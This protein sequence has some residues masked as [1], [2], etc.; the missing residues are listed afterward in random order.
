[1]NANLQPSKCKGAVMEVRQLFD[2]ASSTYSYLVWDPVSREAV[3]IDPVQDQITRDLQLIR[4]IQS[5]VAAI[6]LKH[7]SMQTMSPGQDC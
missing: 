2:P 5:A 7:M 4:K 6:P 3:L 1:M